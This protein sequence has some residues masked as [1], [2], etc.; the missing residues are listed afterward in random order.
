[1]TGTLC[2]HSHIDSWVVSL[3]PICQTEGEKILKQRHCYN[4][5]IEA[6]VEGIRQSHWTELW[7][8]ERLSTK[9]EENALF[10]HTNPNLCRHEPWILDS[11]G[12]FQKCMHHHFGLNS[13][14]RPRMSKRC[15]RV[16]FIPLLHGLVEWAVRNSSITYPGFIQKSF[17]THIESIQDSSTCNW[18]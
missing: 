6:S 12:Y 11:W 13:L 9:L 10:V 4:M 5:N 8:K 7:L 1:M 17:R 18:E 15:Y 14:V 3:K 2:C 16:L